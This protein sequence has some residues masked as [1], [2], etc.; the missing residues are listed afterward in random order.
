MNNKSKYNIQQQPL[1][2]N[3]AT[4]ILKSEYVSKHKMKARRGGGECYYESKYFSL[5]KW[6]KGNVTSLV[7][8]STNGVIML[9]TLMASYQ[10][11]VNL[12]ASCTARVASNFRSYRRTYRESHPNFALVSPRRRQ[13]EEIA[14][15][16]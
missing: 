11:Y 4:S 16:F 15:C 3:L 9:Y 6:R 10:L 5:F 8:P 1:V 7:L 12:F 13:L 2:N 14:P